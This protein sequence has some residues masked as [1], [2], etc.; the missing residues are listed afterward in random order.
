MRFR[1][2]HVVIAVHDLA[3]AVEDYRA[4]GFTVQMGGRHPGRTSH[5]ALV[6]FEDGAYLELIAWPEPGP[7][8]R[9]YNVLTAHGEG[10]MDFAL[11]PEDVPRAIDEARSRG[12]TMNGPVDGSRVRPDGRE[13]KWR[14]GRQTTFDLPFFC[15]DVTPRE[16]RVPGGDVRR[17]ANGA[18][19]VARIAVG[20]HDVEVSRARYRALLGT[21]DLAVGETRLELVARIAAPEGPCAMTIRTSMPSKAGRLDTTLTHRAAIELATAAH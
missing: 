8:E 15:G 6:A 18:L 20:V 12:L 1:L 21:P 16:L 3:R 17:H 7:A 19:G 11:I 13:I 9:W 5:N 14:T 10:F 2:D 4:L